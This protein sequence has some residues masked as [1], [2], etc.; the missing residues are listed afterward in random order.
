MN[1]GKRHLHGWRFLHGIFHSLKW[2][3][4]YTQ[5]LWPVFFS[6]SKPDGEI[7]D[8][9]KFLNGPAINSSGRGG[10]NQTR[11]EEITAL[12][13]ETAGTVLNCAACVRQRG[14]IHVLRTMCVLV[15]YLPVLAVFQSVADL[16][17]GLEQE[18]FESRR[19]LPTDAQLVFQQPDA[20]H[21]H[22]CWGV[23]GHW[24]TRRW[25]RLGISKTSETIKDKNMFQILKHCSLLSKPSH[26][27]F[28]LSV[29]HL[30]DT[31]KGYY[32]TPPNQALT[33]SNHFWERCQEN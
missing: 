3:Q 21:R 7:Y 30:Q 22:T 33:A 23:C 28:G 5:W 31:R 25:K 20:A 24:E 29:E 6:W 13:W 10:L 8:W 27:K 18:V 19:G 26:K 32:I 16:V 17:F 4:R 1:S 14:E 11:L 2:K 15:L 9:W 12:G